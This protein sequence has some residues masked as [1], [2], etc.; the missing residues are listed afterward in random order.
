MCVCYAQHLGA[1]NLAFG[2]ALHGALVQRQHFGILLVGIFL[3]AEIGADTNGRL[4][5]GGNG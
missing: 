2:N 1:N 4:S 3:V 5:G